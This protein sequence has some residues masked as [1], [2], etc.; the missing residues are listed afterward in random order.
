MKII[1]AAVMHSPNLGDGLIADCMRSALHAVEPTLE[2]EYLDLA[3]REKLTPPSKGIRTIVLGALTKIPH[4]LAEPISSFLVKTQIKIHLAHSIPKKL[5][6]TD[7][8]ILGG[9]QLFGD[10]NLN[11]P[12]K[13]AFLIREAEA[14]KIP[15]S[16]HGVGVIQD[17]TP[18]A[19]NLFARVLRSCSLNFISVRDQ[20]SARNLKAHYASINVD[21]PFQVLVF[22]DPG[23]KAETLKAP[24]LNI[25]G[26]EPK[27]GLG[28]VHPT[29][30]AM[31]SP[32]GK[33]PSKGKA[34]TAY[35]EFLSRIN[36]AGSIHLFTNGAGE[37]EEMLD[38]VWAKAS[39]M[40]NVFRTPRFSTP[41]E[42]VSFMHEIDAVASHRLHTAIAANAVGTPALGFRWDRKVDAYFE[43]TRQSNR[44]FSFPS[45]SKEAEKTILE[46]LS[47]ITMTTLEKLKPKVEDGVRALLSAQSPNRAES[48]RPNEDF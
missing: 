45:Q 24:S 47:E 26:E 37:D 15:V 6:K 34:I 17:W 2:I 1:I 40:K 7:L 35:I 32:D 42:L 12:H 11:F 27:I 48:P 10:S 18:R 16:I 3:G 41:L 33:S 22:P 44:L 29:A 36:K 14:R 46:P 5:A 25:P 4:W 23:L 20:D 21:P 8:I 9:G 30:I 19:K 43:L 31:H 39:R 38:A 28:I 13:L